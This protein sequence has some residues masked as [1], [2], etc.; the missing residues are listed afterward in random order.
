MK[1][2][3]LLLYIFI[4]IICFSMNIFADDRKV[5]MQTLNPISLQ[6]SETTK[7]AN[8]YRSL[9]TP[10]ES[11]EKNGIVPISIDDI[12]SWPT[13]KLYEAIYFLQSISQPVVTIYFIFGAILVL[14]GAVSSPDWGFKGIFIM[15]VSVVI[16]TLIFYAP[17]IFSA[18]ASWISS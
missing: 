18:F 17:T 6:G 4:F 5:E 11:L 3:I 15:S 14:L 8:Y 16:C 9:D 13:K 7:T 12:I 1:K 2:L 10:P